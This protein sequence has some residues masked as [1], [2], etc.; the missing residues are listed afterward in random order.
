M[1]RIRIELL[2][3]VFLTLVR[4]QPEQKACFRA[5]LLRCLDREEAALNALLADALLQGTQRYPSP[6]ALSAALGGGALQPLVRK[7]G[8]VQAF[9]FTAV[10]PDD[11][12]AFSD[13]MQTLAGVLL[14]P[15]TR[16]GQLK[17]E[18]VTAALARREKAAEPDPFDGLI[19]H[20][21]CY[22]DYALPVCG[23]DPEAGPNYYQKLSKHYRSVLASSVVE[24]YCAASGSLREMARII[25]DCFGAMPRG[26]IDW[27]LGTDVRMN[28]VEAEPRELDRAGAQGAARVSVGWRLGD[29][30]EDPDV[31]VFEAMACAVRQQTAARETAVR[32]DVHKGA[33]MAQCAVDPE[34]AQNAVS[35][36][37]AAAENLAAEAITQEALRTAVQPRLDAL[38]AVEADPAAL[39]AFWLEQDVL[40]LELAPDE[41]AAFIQEAGP[42]AVRQAAASLECD[43]IIIE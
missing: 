37:R 18:A 24:L 21:F 38:R 10:F 28:A 42:D 36:L 4:Q 43:A 19:E 39:E 23:A 41:Y 17:K 25:A 11:P 31:P 26:E 6:E 20:M 22:E 9:G 40:G 2:D 15:D 14:A 27:E 8:E 1:E 7:L 29:M 5:A 12:S 30:M 32:L 13:R 34:D 3:G 35:D 16:F 33:L